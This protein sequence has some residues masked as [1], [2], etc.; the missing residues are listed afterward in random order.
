MPK[1][2]KG[3]HGDRIA[4]S[5][6]LAQQILDEYAVKQTGRIKNRIRHEEDDEVGCIFN[7]VI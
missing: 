1:I 2:K 5:G 4:R 7:H 6:P 3:V